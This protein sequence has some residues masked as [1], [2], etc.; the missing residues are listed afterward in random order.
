MALGVAACGDG[1]SAETPE[2]TLCQA[3]G[4]YAGTLTNLQG[5][6]LQSTKSQVTIANAATDDAWA[7]VEAAAA[8]VETARID[9]VKTARDDL[10]TAIENIPG[11]ESVAGAIRSVLP[12]V[13]ALGSAYRDAVS[14]LDCET[15]LQ[16]DQ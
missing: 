15:R 10:S 6:S 1:D 2:E 12:Q 13:A 11:N 16:P 4:V 3:L 5:L 9:A 14:G 7:R 8:D